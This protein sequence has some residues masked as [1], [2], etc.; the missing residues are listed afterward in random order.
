MKLLVKNLQ[1]LDFWQNGHFLT[2]F[3]QK[4][5]QFW[6]FPRVPLLT[7]TSRHLGE[8]FRKFSAKTNVKIW[9]YKSKT[10]KILDFWPKWP[11]FDSFWPKMGKKWIF[12][13]NPLGTFFYIPKA[14]S[15]CKV[16][17]KINVGIPRYRVTYGRTLDWS[18]RWNFERDYSCYGI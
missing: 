5:P 3:G 9:S 7:H 18:L 2:L 13:K 16:S 10:F 1:K 12:I 4:N 15:N 11:F 14:L 6:I 8:D 17:E